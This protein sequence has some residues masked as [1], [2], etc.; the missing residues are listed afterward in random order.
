MTVQRAFDIRNS[1]SCAE[2]DGLLTCY[3]LL[4]GK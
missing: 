2:E 3:S 4:N 1:Y